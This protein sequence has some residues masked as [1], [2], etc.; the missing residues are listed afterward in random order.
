MLENELRKKIG[1]EQVV[2][3]QTHFQVISK[4]GKS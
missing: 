2:F 4:E 3:G 1:I